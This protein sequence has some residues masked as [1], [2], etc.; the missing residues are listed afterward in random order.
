MNSF[1]VKDNGER[2]EFNSGMVRDTATGKPRFDLCIPE[3]MPYEEQLLTRFAV[4]MAKGADKYSERNW[5]K[6][7]GEEELSRFKASFLRHANQWVNGMD[8][9]DHAS[10]C[11]FN[12][13]G[14]EYVKWRMKQ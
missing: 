5:E 10:A 11:L 13:M 14:A 2:K 6:A 1:E 8:D 7:S 3:A 4:H 9:E 12:L